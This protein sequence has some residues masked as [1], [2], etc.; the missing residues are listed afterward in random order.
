MIQQ[1]FDKWSLLTNFKM[2]EGLLPDFRD[3]RSERCALWEHSLADV[4]G[5][6]EIGGRKKAPEGVFLGGQGI[7]S[8]R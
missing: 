7:E 2:F 5:T 6:F 1:S 3:E 8:L 4:R